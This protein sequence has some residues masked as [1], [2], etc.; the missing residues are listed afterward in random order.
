MTT[1]TKIARA[2]RKLGLSSLVESQRFRESVGA[3]VYNR[4]V[5]TPDSPATGGPFAGPL[6]TVVV[7]TFNVASYLRECLDSVLGQSYSNLDVL[8]VDDGSSD[9]SGLIADEYA[10]SHKRVRVIHQQNS[11]LG[12]AR[13]TGL[14][15]S[16][17]DFITFVDS[18]D[19]IPPGTYERAMSS[20]HRTGSDVCIGSVSRFDSR[21]KWLPFWVHLAHDEDRLSIT[22]NEFP[23]IM[24]DV[25]AWNKVYRRSAWDRLVG[26]FPEG[27][28]YEDQECTAKLYVGGAQLD[29]LKEVAYNWRLREDNSSITQQKTNI[30][31]LTQRLDVAFRVRDVIRESGEQY[32]SYWY[33]KTLGEDLFYYIREVPRADDAFFE[34]L[35]D[36]TLQLWN[37]APASAFDA[38]DPVRRA[39]AYFVSHRSRNDL[40]RLLVRLEQTRNAF[41]GR[42]ERGQLR[43]SIQDADGEEFEIPDDLQYVASSSLTPRVKLDSY[44]ARSNGDV[45]FG[46]YGYI[47]NFDVEYGYSADLFDPVSETVVSTLEVHSVEGQVPSRLSDSY[48][49]YHNRRLQLDFPRFVID[50]IAEHQDASQGSNLQL[51]LHVHHSEFTWTE[52]SVKRDLLSSAGFPSASPI[53]ARGARIAIQGDPRQKTEVVVL[54]PRVVAN[55]IQLV[56]NALYV[57]IDTDTKF[58]P[59]SAS[60]LVTDLF[61][62]LS[63]GTIELARSSFTRDGNRL[64]SELAMPRSHILPSKI[65]DHFDLHL[66]SKSGMRWALAIDRSQAGRRRDQD[67]VIGMSGYGYAAIDRPLQVATAHKVEIAPDGTSIQVKGSFALNPA[68]ARAVT[69]T[70][71]LVGARRVIHPSSIAVDQSART[72]DALFSLVGSRGES[73]LVGDRYVLQLL[74]ATGKAHP[75]SAWV[76]ASYE[77]EDSS[78][79]Q[80]LTPGCLITMNIVGTSRSVRVDLENPLDPT[81][82]VGTW[83]QVQNSKVFISPGQALK[84]ST[85]LFESFSGN[86]IS[87]SPL[88][89]DNEIKERYPHVNRL[90][91]VRDP[92]VTVPEGA[93]SVLFGSQE[94]FDAASTAKVLINNNNFPH[95][96]RKHTDQFYIQTWHGTPLKRI[97]N[98]V[99]P[100][101]LSLS[102][103]QL[104]TRESEIY[105]NLLLAQSEWA[106]ETLKDA[107]NYTGSVLATGYPR[108]DVLAQPDQLEA[109]RRKIREQ[110]GINPGQRVV[111]YAPTWRDNLKDPSGHYSSVD[112]LNV[113]SASKKLGQFSTILYR[114]HSNSLNAAPR[115]FAEAVIDVSSYP[116]INDL[117]AASDVLVTDY[118]SIMFDYVV[119]GR[120]II[121][122]CPDL[123]IY[124]DSVRG[125]YLDFEAT[126]PGP[127][128][129]TAEEAIEIL[130]SDRTFSLDSTERYSNFVN[131]FASL[132]DGYSSKRVVDE[133][134]R[135]FE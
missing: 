30:T 134:S 107:F 120:P 113:N 75:A 42:N 6:L 18:D 68:V 117:I 32:L 119:T 93:K 84:S 126:A 49:N 10:R 127:V 3:P 111:L 103:R 82:E 43:F 100:K 71:A 2:M 106:A 5:P 74:L 67:F 64:R 26:R 97:G 59:A 108:N 27:T 56:D 124:R 98:H 62:S 12:A 87:D 13:N 79:Q 123:D 14:R 1:K 70:F 29:V 109:S 104:M 121:F 9:G 89:L 25:F 96:F 63:S 48:H 7:P 94:W 122:L 92:R 86:A 40:E 24:W 50:E 99:P 78:P 65:L 112:F 51:R 33:T 118:S 28:L 45:V 95:F 55:E 80:T 129:E 69:P 38:I 52:P 130:R 125:F 15:H 58:L 83:N 23:P 61:L 44:L 77:L 19:T 47:P 135:L 16:E 133:V 4:S 11:G 132:D 37:D 131:R 105:W 57:Q 102:Y 101:S 31:D 76:T 115:R 46:G 72:F 90:W 66:V 8:I 88:A 35:S 17:S 54:R 60:T 22:G 73:T 41:R 81:S 36:R 39:L 114:G 21:N 91:T 110:L 34:L 116:D 20:L 128:V 53:T 85:I